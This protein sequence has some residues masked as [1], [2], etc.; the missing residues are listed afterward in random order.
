MNRSHLSNYNDLRITCFVT[1]NKRMFAKVLKVISRE[2]FLASTKSFAMIHNQIRM[3]Y[4]T[5]LLFC[6]GG[7]TQ[8]ITSN[9]WQ[10]KLRS[11]FSML[12]KNN[13]LRTPFQRNKIVRQMFFSSTPVGNLRSLPFP[14]FFSFSNCFYNAPNLK[15]SSPV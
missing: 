15:Q 9:S 3:T 2:R 6:S 1:R 7:E 12:N 13:L 5:L 8:P 11:F 10:G 14:S 4:D